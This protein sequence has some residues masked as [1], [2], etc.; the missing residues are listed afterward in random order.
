MLIPK[1]SLKNTILYSSIIAIFIYYMIGVIDAL[2]FVNYA[3]LL[4]DTWFVILLSVVACLFILIVFIKKAHFHWINLIL[5]FPFV[6]FKHLEIFIIIAMLIVSLYWII[7]SYQKLMDDIIPLSITIFISTY[8]GYIQF[9]WDT[10]NRSLFFII[11]GILLFLI[12]YLFE[13][14]RRKVEMRAIK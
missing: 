10:M 9:A 14:Q 7:I 6:I 8:T 2:Y 4:K 5:L 11:G 12:S 13:R 1:G 3:D